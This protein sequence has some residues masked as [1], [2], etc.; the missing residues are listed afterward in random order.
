M[1]RK[2]AKLR[3]VGDRY[4]RRIHKDG[5]EG[6]ILDAATARPAQSSTDAELIELD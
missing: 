5:R 6:D 1:L 3:Q 4:W 2:G